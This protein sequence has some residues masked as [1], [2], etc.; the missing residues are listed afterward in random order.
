MQFSLLPGEALLSP[1][2]PVPLRAPRSPWSGGL[3]SQLRFTEQ[4][5]SG[6]GRQRSLLVTQPV[7][8]WLDHNSSLSLGLLG[9]ALIK[10]LSL[11]L[12]LKKEVR[13]VPGDQDR[14][15]QGSG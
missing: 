15:W 11:I 13:K 1:L 10:S 9:L 3:T 7:S 6:S 14:N 12:P 4:E 8:K 2:M 5:K